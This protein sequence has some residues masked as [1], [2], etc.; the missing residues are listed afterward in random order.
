MLTSISDPDIILRLAS[1]SDTIELIA[2]HSARA[3][4]ADLLRWQCGS[5]MLFDL[6]YE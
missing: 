6:Y 1:T 4:S 2:S 3:A 5:G